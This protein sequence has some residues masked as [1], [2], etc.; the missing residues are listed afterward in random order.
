MERSI[1]NACEHFLQ[2]PVFLPLKNPDPSLP[3]P[4]SFYVDVLNEIYLHNHPNGG[5]RAWITRSLLGHTV[6]TA[7]IVLLSFE[8][9][10]TL[11]S[12]LSVLCHCYRWDYVPAPP[13]IYQIKKLVLPD[14]LW[15]PF[16]F[17]SD[18]LKSPY[19]GTLYSTTTSNF[20]LTTCAPGVDYRFDKVVFEDIA[21]NCAWLPQIY[22]KE[23]EQWVK[24]FVMTE[25]EGGHANQAAVHALNSVLRCDAV[26]VKIQLQALLVGIQRLTKLFGVHVRGSKLDIGLWRN[27]VQPIFIWGLASDATSEQPL[28]GA[29][30]LQVGC[31]QLIDLIL[32]TKMESTMGRAMLN[33]RKYMPERFRQLFDELEPFRS[34]VVDFVNQSADEEIIDLYNSCLNATKLYRTSH[35]QR[36]KIYINGD[37]QEKLI[38]TTGLSISQ[39]STAAVDFEKDMLERIHEVHQPILAK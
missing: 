27:V 10:E 35:M 39:S 7:Q 15:R 9:K 13:D 6:P 21:I 11:L 16:C 12:V 32:G 38:T 2:H 3:S 4:F 25:M 36:G 31:I 5:C 23:L 20:H 22:A 33:S 26:A 29:S 19:C 1:P 17:L 30:G 8:Q 34:T 14:N 18:L 24:I 37:G 28:E